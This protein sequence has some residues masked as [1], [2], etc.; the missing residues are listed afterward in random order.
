MTK[1]FNP[2]PIFLDARGN[3]MDGGHIY[4][5]TANADPV[6]S[7]IACFW[8]NARTIPATQPLRTIGGLIVNGTTPASAFFAET[9][10]STTVNDSG[11]NLVYYAPSTYPAGS[12]Q[13]LDS[14]L[15]AIA[16]LTT[17]AYG[18]ALLTLANQGA[19]QTAVGLP[20][21]LPLTGGTVTGNIVRSGAGVLPYWSDPLMTGGKIFITAVGASD[22]TSAPGDLWLVY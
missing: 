8:D 21:A 9:D 5:G 14:D 16:A 6:T 18:R 11:G 17:T 7:P 10:Y 3:L 13:P 20:A 15:T 4:I 19:L 2:E 12:Y 1:L 22:P